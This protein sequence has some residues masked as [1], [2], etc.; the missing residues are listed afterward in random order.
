[1]CAKL[2]AQGTVKWFSQDKGYGFITPDDG[3]EDIFVHFSAIQGD[4]ANA[5]VPKKVD[6][7]SLVK[8]ILAKPR[9]QR[10]RLHRERYRRERALRPWSG[11]LSTRQSSGPEARTGG[12]ARAPPR[13]Y[14]QLQGSRLPSSGTVVGELTWMRDEEIERKIAA[15]L[16]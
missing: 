4:R 15:F 9:H 12:R 14:A 8:A 5:N 10:A 7:R 1:V 6:G 13:R 3:G 11:P 2:V 16:R